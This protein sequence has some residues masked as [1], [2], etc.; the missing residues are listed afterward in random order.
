ML[1]YEYCYQVIVRQISENYFY[2]ALF[3]S[4]IIFIKLHRLAFIWVI[5]LS[6]SIFRKNWEPNLIFPFRCWIS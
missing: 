3:L 2:H 6:A 5:R 4:R 1:L